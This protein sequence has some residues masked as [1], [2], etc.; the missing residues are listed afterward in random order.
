MKRK[1]PC[2]CNCCDI[3][4]LLQHKS[5]NFKHKEKLNS[6]E[7][8]KNVSN[9]NTILDVHVDSFLTIL[10]EHNFDAE[11]IKEPLVT[12]MK[13][14]SVID[15]KPLIVIEVEKRFAYHKKVLKEKEDD[16]EKIIDD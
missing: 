8:S 4:V 1:Y 10:D 5:H 12:F 6:I 3:P 7:M 9:A 2:H 15:V 16:L 13:T 11:S 14:K